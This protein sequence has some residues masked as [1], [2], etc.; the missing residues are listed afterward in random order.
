VVLVVEAKESAL[1]NFQCFSYVLSER[2]PVDR[3]LVYVLDL[4]KLVVRLVVYLL[5]GVFVLYVYIYLSKH[6]QILEHCGVN[7]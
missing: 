4:D 1:Y 6:H 7:L 5:G 2:L 3:R